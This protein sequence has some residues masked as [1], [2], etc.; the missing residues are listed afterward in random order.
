MTA[1]ENLRGN[2]KELHKMAELLF[3][4]FEVSRVLLLFEASR[5]KGAE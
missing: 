4:T 5:A 3:E 2:K 1:M